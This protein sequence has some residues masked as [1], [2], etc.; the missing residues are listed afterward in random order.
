MQGWK[1]PIPTEQK[2]AYISVLLEVGFHTLDFG[3]FVSAKAIPQMA[4]TK[5]VIAQLTK[6][7]KTKNPA[8]TRLLAIVALGFVALRSRAVVVPR[9]TYP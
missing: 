7:K 3:S 1:M 2:V 9:L 5:A 6:A 8:G 4:D